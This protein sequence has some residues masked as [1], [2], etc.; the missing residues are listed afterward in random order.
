M[1][2][3]FRAQGYSTDRAEDW[4]SH[5][6][7]DGIYV[8]SADAMARVG[9]LVSRHAEDGTFDARVHAVARAFG[10]ELRMGVVVGAG[11]MKGESIVLNRLLRYNNTVGSGDRNGRSNREEVARE[12]ELREEEAEEAD[13]T[14]VEVD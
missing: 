2:G 13:K 9:D 1:R 6:T 4:V 10:G 14:W 11:R 5:H 12:A 8:A 7:G 3:A